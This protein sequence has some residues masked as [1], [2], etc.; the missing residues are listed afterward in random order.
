M[1]K[2]IAID[3]DGTLLNDHHEVSAEVCDALQAAKAEGVKIVLCTGRPIGGVRRYLDELNLIE[4][5]DYVI[6]YNGALVQNTHTNEVVNEL[7]LG[8]DDLKSL[9]EL[10]L[11]LNTPMHFFDS[12]RLY[13]PNRDISEYTVYESYVTQVPLHYRKLEEISEDIVIPKVMYIDKPENLSH[14]ISSI[15]EDVKEKYTMVKSAPFF[16]E[17]LHPEASKGNAV[18]QLAKLLGIEQ[19]EVMSIGDNGNDLTMI[20]WAGCG[21]AMANAIPEV[22][23]AADFQTRSNNEHGVA[24]AIHELVLKK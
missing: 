2:L 21:V 12:S 8:Y 7:S 14:V 18:R 4:E 1:Y 19:Q 17:I 11:E 3:M 20:E 23:E 6:A 13:T 15:P 9:Y 10:S 22:R 16:Y 5:G 24:Y